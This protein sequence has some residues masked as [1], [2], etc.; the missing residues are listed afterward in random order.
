MRAFTAQRRRC[1]GL[2]RSAG[3]VWAA[4][5][6][7]NQ[8]R[9]A[10][11]GRPVFSYVELCRELAGTDLGEL[12]VD[13]ARSVLR[14]YSEACFETARRKNR[15]ERARY[16]RR[17]RGLFPVRFYH[18]TFTLDGRR[19]RLPVAKGCAP[20]WVRLPRDIPYEA[21]RVR[22]VTLLC[23]AGG[24]YLDVTAAVAVED[25]DLDPDR[26][27]GVDVGIIHPFAVVGPDSAGMVVSGRALRAEERL[28]LE[29]TKRR[30]ARMG[31]KA[32][33]RGQ[34]GS[35]RWRKLRRTQRAAEA[36]HIRKVRQTH[37]EA[38]KEVVAWAVDRRVGTLVVGDPKGITRNH[39][40]RRQNRRVNTQWRRT[41]L[42][43]ALTDKATRAGIN[44]VLVDERGTSSTCPRCHQRVSKPR[45]RAFTCAACGLI[46]HRDLVGATNIAARG[47]GI[48]DVP[49][50][51]SSTHRRAGTP[52][53]RRD[54]RRHLWDTRRTTRRSCPTPGRPTPP[55]GTGSRSTKGPNS[56]G[57]S[58]GPNGPHRTHAALPEDRRDVTITSAM[59]Y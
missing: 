36:R 1:F 18:G 40:G 34:R 24:V 16:P 23:E 55:H 29:D 57:T 28:H 5:I 15:G 33:R 10:R 38:A 31:R 20:L 25:Y 21:T 47:G 3:D 48:L 30:A 13:G 54:R 2:L 12:S 58:Q 8:A 42:T 4:L 51:T 45:G 9:F 32:P 26:V 50:E 17:R 52:P 39:A 14:R 53:T 22:S 19:V 6:E 49:D 59:E 27:A 41:H 35:R 43:A 7:F 37:H 44:V 11:G 56:H 46:A